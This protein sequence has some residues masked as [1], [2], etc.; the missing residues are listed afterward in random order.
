MPTAIKRRK[1][2][3]APRKTTTS[4][5]RQQI[6]AFTKV[7]KGAN[8]ASKTVVDKT[9]AINTIATTVPQVEKSAATGGKRKLSEIDED[10]VPIEALLQIPSASKTVTSSKLLSRTRSQLI[11]STP[12]KSAIKSTVNNTVD[13]PTKGARS[14]LDRLLLTSTTPTKSPL[15]TKPSHTPLLDLNT[16]PS[17]QELPTELLDLVNLHAA[18]LTALSLHYAHNGINSPACLRMLCPNVARAWGKRSVTLEDI[19]RTIGV[20][21]A[22]ILERKK[23][24]ATPQLTLSD[25]GHGKICIEIS[26]SAG[27]PGTIIARPVNENLLNEIFSGGLKNS[28]KVNSSENMDIKKFIETLP[29]EPITTCSSLL[30]MSPM[31]AKGQRRLGDFKVGIAVAKEQERAKAVEA[32]IAYTTGAATTGTK[33]TL[34]ERLRAKQLEKANQAPPPTKVE[35]AR[36]VAIQKIEEVAAVLVH[37]STSSSVGQTRISFTL[38]TVIGKLRDSLKTPI[39]KVESETCLRL[40]ASDIA[41]E[42]VKMVKMGKSEALVVNRDERPTEASISERVK[43]AS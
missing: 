6:G 29:L 5:T 22:N 18:F 40:L 4:A 21:N 24:D 17:S 35:L 25:Y 20:L 2:S 36:K 43:S 10:E 15:K 19:R 9:N 31:L 12:R 28:W 42:W 23:K 8:V 16:P 39:S 1:L 13:T 41:P 11:P 33:P 3:T 30:K 27:K 14:L 37:L 34:L 7:S 38:P 32:E 26:I